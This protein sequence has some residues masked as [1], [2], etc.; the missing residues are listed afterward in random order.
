MERQLKAAEAKS[1]PK[2][3]ENDAENGPKKKKGD[4]NAAAA[5]LRAELKRVHS[6][7]N[8]LDTR[9]V[10]LFDSFVPKLCRCALLSVAPTLGVLCDM[11]SP[12][13]SSHAAAWC[14][15]SCGVHSAHVQRG[16]ARVSN[17]MC[18]CAP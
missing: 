8:D 2:I 7:T 12:F 6:V 14:H 3:G 16:I 4:E 11:E 15:S 13:T 18:A 10:A 5:T 17:P 1:G 9:I